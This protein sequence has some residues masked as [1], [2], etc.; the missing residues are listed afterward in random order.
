[1]EYYYKLDE[2]TA[3]IVNRVI[4]ITLTDYEVKGTFIPINS[5]ISM[6]EDLICEVERK[7]E[8]LNNLKQDV[9][10]NYKQITPSEM[11]DITDND[12]VEIL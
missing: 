3:K 10:D 7:E 11:Y 2:N 8:E 4:K 5:F 9:K 12:F 6:I 1:M